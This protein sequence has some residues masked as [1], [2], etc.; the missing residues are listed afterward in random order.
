MHGF[1]SRFCIGASLASWKFIKVTEN[2]DS[3]SNHASPIA[4]GDVFNGIFQIKR[5]VGRG[6]MGEVFEGVNIS[7]DERV[8]IKVMLPALAAD[9]R[10]ELMFRNEARI[11]TKLAHPALVQYRVMA[12]EPNLDLLYIVMDYIDGVSLLQVIDSIGATTAELI[13]LMRRLA[14][15]LR[16]AHKLGAIHGD[17]TPDNVLLERG[18]LER[19]RIVDFGIARNLNPAHGLAPEGFSGKIG[20]AAPEQL[21]DFGGVI[22]PWTDVYGLGLLIL[23]LSLG[24]KFDFGSTIESAIARRWVPIDLSLVRPELR[25]LL[26]T[27]LA[28]DPAARLRSMDAVLQVLDE[29]NFDK[30][31]FALPQSLFTPHDQVATTATV[32]PRRQSLKDS[33]KAAET[34]R[35]SL[36]LWLIVG[37]AAAAIAGLGWWGYTGFSNGKNSFA[38]ARSVAA[39]ENCAW[40]NVAAPRGGNIIVVTGAANDPAA[41]KSSIALAIGDVGSNVQVDVAGVGRLDPAACNLIDTVRKM[42]SGRPILESLQ[43]I[44]PMHADAVPSMPGVVAARTQPVLEIGENGKPF[45]V[46]SMS[47]DGGLNWVMDR[48]LLPE[49]IQKKRIEL[50]GAERIRLTFDTDQ[51]GWLGVLVVDGQDKAQAVKWTVPQGARTPSWYDQ[52][53]ADA[54]KNGWRADM[55]WFAATRDGTI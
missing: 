31:L 50:V 35:A 38:A 27:M 9:P 23:S 53:S 44:Y 11:L 32:E 39:S 54:Q 47:P 10:V 24:R 36:R 19:A 1:G 12:R 18:R 46:Y 26:Q 16:E 52:I 6:G 42:R 49:M 33:A 15:G 29:S 45:T 34:R 2:A 51:T 43:S 14:T 4:I 3:P 28:A 5:F 30:T 17:L 13:A 40:L 25:P 22:G 21:G 37:A 48:S 41:L 8:A 55:I 7:T 20:F